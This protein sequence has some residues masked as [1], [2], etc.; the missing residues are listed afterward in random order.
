MENWQIS[1]QQLIDDKEFDQAR[2]SLE[3]RRKQLKN[4]GQG[5]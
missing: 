1:R 2:K 4:T 3:I 5:K